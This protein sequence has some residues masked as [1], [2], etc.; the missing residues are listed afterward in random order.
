MQVAHRVLVINLIIAL[1]GA[2]AL[3]ILV[4]IVSAG[5][6]K[7]IRKLLKGTKLVEAGDYSTQVNLDSEDEIG[8]LALRFNSMTTSIH[9]N[10]THLRMLQTR[11]ESILI[12]TKDLASSRNSVAAAQKTAEYI[13]KGVPVAENCSVSASFFV[14]SDGLFSKIRVHELFRAGIPVAEAAIEIPLHLVHADES[15]SKDWESCS[16]T[17]G[18]VLLPV[19]M[20]QKRL[21]MLMF[22]GYASKE[23]DAEDA[24]FMNTFASS[25]AVS[26]ENISYLSQTGEKAK[27]EAEFEATR[28]VQE[29]L[30]P[31]H[32]KFPNL[33]IA[34]HFKPAVLAGGDW[35]GHYYDKTLHRMNFFIGDVTGHGIASALITGVVCGGVYAGEHRADLMKDSE[36]LH[37]EKRLL[38][39]AHAV[40]SVVFI[41]GRQKKL[42]TMAFVSLDLMTGELLY[43]NAGHNPIY[44]VQGKERVIKVVANRGSRLG[45]TAE[46]DFSVKKIQLQAG[47]I[48]F[49]YTD[50]LIENSGPDDET[51]RE[52]HLKNLL[53]LPLDVHELNRKI[54]SECE[55]IWQAEPPR[56]D[57]TTLVVQWKGPVNRG[58]FAAS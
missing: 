44:F 15:S 48:I 30:L 8:T 39:L 13:L 52:R 18:R 40:N 49:M 56:D 6:T 19:V 21:C 27:L 55:K 43:L 1:S 41:T 26:L 57:V 47:D 28:A 31:V 3:F 58:D 35:Y 42:M 14:E 20:Q 25:L 4:W 38:A 7:S 24:H 34:T 36:S 51:I 2:L 22:D 23:I 29:Q 10:I 50:G 32:S 5:L 12:G 37:P 17:D 16:L 46:G 9:E 33:E 11:L 54:I 53:A 45:F